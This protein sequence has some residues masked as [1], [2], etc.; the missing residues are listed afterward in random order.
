M[1]VK[2]SFLPDLAQITEIAQETSDTKSFKLRLQDPQVQQSFTF[3]PGQFAEVSVFGVGEAP[4][5]FASSPTR[6]DGLLITVRD[7]GSVTHALHSL[8]E[9]D[10]V[11]VRGP[12]GNHFPFEESQGKDIL[13]VGGGI[14]LP[15]LHSLIWNMLDQRDLFGKITILYGA[16]TPSDLVY[17]D[18][19]K[20]WEAREDI[21]FLVTVDN[22]EPG[23]EGNVGVVT[24]LFEK[25][26]LR[27]ETSV[28]YVCGPPIMIKFVISDLLKMDFAEESI[29]STLE[30]MMKC[31]IGKCNHCLIGHKYV[32]LDGPVFSYREMKKFM[33]EE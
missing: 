33:E 10:V 23:W 28:A 2:N 20:E 4:F 15:P 14:G 12:F 17:K 18:V 8:Q 30:R 11:G 25:T 7:V 3:R 16:R 27:P 19:L 21:E 6:N 9:G 26:E 29:I 24:T 32:C 5:C 1:A 31:G 22:A 13:F